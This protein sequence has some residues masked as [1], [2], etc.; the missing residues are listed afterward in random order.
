M[1]KRH[2][3]VLLDEVTTTLAPQAGEIVFDGTLGEGGHARMLCDAVG[4]RGILIGI[5]R[6]A[7]MLAIAKTNLLEG[8]CTTRF[9]R[10]NFKDLDRVLVDVGI[11]GVDIIVLDLG[12]NSAQL[13]DPHR[14]FSFMQNAPL[15]MSYDGKD[16]NRLAYFINMG[17]EEDIV[18]VL[19]NYGEEQFAKKIAREIIRA[20]KAHPMV[21]TG[22]LVEAIA[23]AVPA[24][25]RRQKRH[26]ATKTFQALRIYVNEELDA[27]SIGLPKAWHALRSGGRLAV[28]SFHSL[29]DRVVKNFF[30][31]KEREGVGIPITK[32]AIIPTGEEIRKNPRSRSAKL[33][34]IKKI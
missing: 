27:L 13:A 31:D 2:I 6:D 19:F 8:E 14:G 11:L 5:D 24:G 20:R 17:R 4:K 32:K 7:D 3:P 18:E 33:R 10:A 9:A 26:F 23:R 28:I 29:E 30:K 12:M 21:R 25:Y 1:D 34:I 15:V 16:D 22:E